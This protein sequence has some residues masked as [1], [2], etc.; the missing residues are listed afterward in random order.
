MFSH[1]PPS[2]SDYGPYAPYSG[3]GAREAEAEECDI[4]DAASVLEALE[5]IGHGACGGEVPVLGAEM[6][7][8]FSHDESPPSI[9]WGQLPPNQQAQQLH[10]Y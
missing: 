7:D 3:G 1:S 4:T 6:A 2:H 5:M 8:M 10:H 9:E